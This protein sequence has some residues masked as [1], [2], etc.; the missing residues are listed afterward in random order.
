MTSPTTYEGTATSLSLPSTRVDAFNVTLAE[1]LLRGGRRSGLT[2]APEAGTERMRKVIN[3][4][5]SEADLLRTAETAYAN[6]WRQLK[7]YFMIGL[8]TETDDDVVGIA[9]L[10]LKVAAIAKQHG[11]KNTVTVSVGGFVPKPH[12]PFQWA[13]Q[14]APE[15][16][17]AS[18]PAQGP[19]RGRARAQPA[20]PRP[21]ARGGRGPAGPRRPP[22]RRGRAARVRAGRPLRRLGRALLSGHLAAGR[23]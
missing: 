9:E 12:T 20:L 1:E 11:R 10:G 2:F 16:L 21:G 8:P 14:D 6:G 19:H 13:A 17:S 5:V 3:K 7:L 22:G 18:W 23:G 15:E 4:M